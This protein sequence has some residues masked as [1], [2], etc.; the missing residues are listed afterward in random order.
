M[1]P[2]NSQ[3]HTFQGDKLDPQPEPPM[4]QMDPQPEP[5]MD[6]LAPQLKPSIDLS[7]GLTFKP[8]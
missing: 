3:H 6:Q 4:D 1:D 2:E 7:P 5:P 8:L